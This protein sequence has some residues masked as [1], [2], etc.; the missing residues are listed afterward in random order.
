MKERRIGRFTVANKLLHAA[1]D[2]GHGANLFA[3]MVPLDI[4]RDFIQDQTTFIAWCPQF[5]VIDEGRI[6]PEYVAVFREG[7]TIPEWKHVEG[8]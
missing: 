8:T 3:G 2:S 4:Q 7:N 1:I 6:I 5:M